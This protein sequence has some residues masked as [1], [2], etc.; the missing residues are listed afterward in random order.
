MEKLTKQQKIDNKLFRELYPLFES[1]STRGKV[2]TIETLIM[3]LS[4]KEV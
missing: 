3:C 2:T 4:L 1:M